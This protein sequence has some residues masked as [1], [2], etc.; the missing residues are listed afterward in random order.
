MTTVAQKMNTLTRLAH[1]NPG[2]ACPGPT[3]TT[4]A[5]IRKTKL[6]RQT[7]AARPRTALVGTV[8]VRFVGLVATIRFA[9]SSPAAQIFRTTWKNRPWQFLS[10]RLER[11]RPPTADLGAIQCNH[12]QS[13]ECGNLSFEFD[14]IFFFTAEDPLLSSDASKRRRRDHK[15]AP[16]V[17]P[18]KAR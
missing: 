3:A 15:L 14:P 11:R 1:S 2:P 16:G 4:A 8:R 7:T 17:S 13:G 10:Y 18:G 5:N 6:S 12:G 9:K